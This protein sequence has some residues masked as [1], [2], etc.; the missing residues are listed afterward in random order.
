LKNAGAAHRWRVNFLIAALALVVLGW[1]LERRVHALRDPR[2]QTMEAY[3]QDR[4]NQAK[5]SAKDAARAEFGQWHGYSVLVNLACVLCV[6][7]AMALAGNLNGS[8]KDTK[9]HEEPK[10][11]EHAEGIF[12]KRGD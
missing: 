8:T 11:D 6:T 4:D 5:I 7:A 10:K 12:V 9:V 1:P 3:L 2:N